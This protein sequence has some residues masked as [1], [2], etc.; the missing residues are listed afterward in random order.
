VI[1]VSTDL[2]SPWWDPHARGTIMG[3]TRGAGRAQL[4]RAVVEAMAFQVRAILDAVVDAIAQPITMLRVDGGAAAM[5]LLLQLQ[6]DQSQIAVARPTTLESTALGAATLAGLAV[7][8][9][10]SLDELAAI[11]KLDREFTPAFDR[12]WVD[13][14]YGI[15]L[16]AL[17]R[18]RGWSVD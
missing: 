1:A 8:M 16:R 10:S 4:A 6:S 3:L 18:S 11:W 7:G 12:A 9:W 13:A 14:L 15:W 2:D 5:D 17:E